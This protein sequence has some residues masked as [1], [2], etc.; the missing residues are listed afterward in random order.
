MKK[1]VSLLV[2]AAMLV[3]GL[4]AV[5]PGTA[6]DLPESDLYTH[7]TGEIS[8]DKSTLTVTTEIGNNPGLWCYRSRLSYNASAL[9]LVS[10]AN[11]NVW[12]DNEYIPAN[13]NNNPVTYYAQY[14][15]ALSNNASNGVIAVYTFEILDANANFNVNLSI[16]PR[17]VFGVDATGNGVFHTMQIINDCPQEL[18]FD[19]TALD[20]LATDIMELPAYDGMSDEQIAKMLA[21]YNSVHAL[22]GKSETYFQNTYAS[23]ITKI[24]ELYAAHQWAAVAVVL[25]ALGARVEALPAYAEMTAEQVQEMLALRTEIA[26]ITEESHKAY[27]QEKF[28]D[29]LARMD[30]S[31]AEYVR[32]EGLNVIG[33]R[34]NALPAYAEMTEAQVQEM[35]ALTADL[36]KLSADDLNYIKNAFAEGYARLEASNA[37]YAHAQELNAI[38]AR[39]NALPAYA[40]MTA[41]QIQEML[42]LVAAVEAMSA[43]DVVYITANFKDGYDRM[44]ASYARYTRVQELDAIAARITALPDDFYAM[45]EANVAEM[46]ALTDIIDA[47][48]AEEDQQYMMDN[49]E[50]AL[51][52]LATLYV[53]YEIEQSVKELAARIEALPN[54]DVITEE[55]LDEVT[56]LSAIVTIGGLAVRFQQEIPQAYENLVNAY[57]KLVYGGMDAVNMDKVAAVVDAVNA[58]TEGQDQ[59]VL[60]LLYSLTLMEEEDAATA[61]YIALARPETFATLVEKYV[62]ILSREEVD[63]EA[64]AALAD[65][66]L[67]LP[68]Y[69]DMTAEDKAAFEEIITAVAGMSPVEMFQFKTLLADAY[70]AYLALYEAYEADKGNGEDKPPVT[71]PDDT[72]AAPGADTTTVPAQNGGDKKPVQ[73]GDN[74]TYIIIA[75]AVAAVACAAVV[76]VR[77]KKE[78]V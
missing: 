55:Y 74:M 41:E 77:K 58:L 25:D 9:K 19:T 14:A 48:E 18:P 7:V 33:A 51:N 68:A 46:L 12:S 17:E 24:D 8:S 60:D 21:L 44:S 50:D 20:A 29:A 34:I 78:T 66:I 75:A 53:T 71:E 37:A 64:L 57:F 56:E 63:I 27:L 54:A 40:E 31:Y 43:E 72:T 62:D 65:K 15:A 28:A 73:T 32:V 23:A 1:L 26:A 11:G 6:A 67:E 76:V 49:H 5:I 3:T 38:G 4:L 10:V 45:T 59:E 47:I 70:E 61:D 13:I 36:A 16:N 39:I 30:A 52:K 69:E 35:L 42:A 2:V 22:T